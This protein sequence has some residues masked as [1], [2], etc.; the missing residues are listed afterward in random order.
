MPDVLDRFAAMGDKMQLAR[1]LLIDGVV[2]EGDVTL[3][4]QAEVNA[5]HYSEVTGGLTIS[6]DDVT[7]V[8]AL[9]SLQR[10]KSLRIVGNASLTNV[11]GLSA[12]VQVGFT[13]DGIVPSAFQYQ[14]CH[15][16]QSLPPQGKFPVLSPGRSGI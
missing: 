2:F 10:V 8:N 7:N 1:E 15:S 13:N 9:A 11:D 4:S 14:W 5:F 3:T 16:C 6:G 12:L